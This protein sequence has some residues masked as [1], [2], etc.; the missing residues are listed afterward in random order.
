M[1]TVI[2]LIPFVLI[3]VAA[4]FFI[5]WQVAR[6]A[7]RGIQREWIREGLRGG[8]GVLVVLAVGTVVVVVVSQFT[9]NTHKVGNAGGIY[10][11]L[12]ATLLLIRR[13][14][15]WSR[16]SKDVDNAR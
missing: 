14:R 16:A 5:R 6:D 13:V 15:R 4:G 11:L 8:V 7:R 3:C 10:I 12:V 2:Q 1:T 9:S